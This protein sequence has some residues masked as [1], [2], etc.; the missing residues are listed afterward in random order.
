MIGLSWS[1]ND[2]RC[3]DVVGAVTVS[4]T[5]SVVGWGMLGVVIVDCWGVLVVVA[6]KCYDGVCCEVSLIVGWLLNAVRFDDEENY[7]GGA[8]YF[9]LTVKWML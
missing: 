6:E 4:W 7:N 3:S 8:F 1:V 5:I 2:L 9:P